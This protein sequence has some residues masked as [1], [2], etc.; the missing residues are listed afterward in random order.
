MCRVFPLSLGDLRLKWFDKLP[1]GSIRSFY[2]LTE[3][4][5]ARFVI[6]TKAL[7]GVSFLLI[8]KGK[9][10]ALYNY[11]KCY[12]ELYNEIEECSEELSMVSYKLEL[13]PGKK[14]WEALTLNPPADLRDL[15]TR[16]L[17]DFSRSAHSGWT[18]EEYVDQEKT[19][20]DEAEIGAVCNFVGEGN[21]EW[22]PPIWKA[23]THVR[24]PHLPLTSSA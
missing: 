2:Q 18:L 13:T 10:E 9:N 24:C 4:F 11:R 17:E 19:K 15:M 16:G 3:S 7:K 22:P 20:A 23:Q 14:L 1:I 8:R 21:P 12:W 5:M 6:N